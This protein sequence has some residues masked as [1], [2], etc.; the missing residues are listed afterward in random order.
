[1]RYFCSTAARVF[2]FHCFDVSVCCRNRLVI[3]L[4]ICRASGLDAAQPR[5]PAS[6]EL[7][8]VIAGKASCHR[9]WQRTQSVRRGGL[10]RLTRRCWASAR[11][12]N[13]LARRRILRSQP[14]RTAQ[15]SSR[16]RITAQSGQRRGKDGNPE[17][18]TRSTQSSRS[19]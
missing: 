4:A 15:V 1:M 6:L 12:P 11:R 13:S 8:E 3:R 7:Y 2:L 17:A 9:M 5:E 18:D 14:P 16:N 10:A 19:P